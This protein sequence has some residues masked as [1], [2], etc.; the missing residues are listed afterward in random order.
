MC[1]TTINCFKKVVEIDKVIKAFSP[2]KH[3]I[4]IITAVCS[5][6][7]VAEPRDGRLALLDEVSFC[8]HFFFFFFCY[9]R[10]CGKSGGEDILRVVLS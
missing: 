1:K 10:V 9:L 8:A 7:A 6:F 4:I 2:H 3:K 5:L